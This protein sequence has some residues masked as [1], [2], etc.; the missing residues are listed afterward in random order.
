MVCLRILVAGSDVDCRS[1]DASTWALRHACVSHALDGRDALAKIF[2]EPAAFLACITQ[3]D[4]PFIDGYVLCKILRTDVLTRHIK[5]VM[6][7]ADARQPAVERA[8]RA[9]AN[10]VIIK[11]YAPERLR[12]E[13]ERL[14]NEPDRGDDLATGDGLAQ[15]APPVAKHVRL[16]HIHERFATAAPPLLPPPIVCPT[17]DGVLTYK[18]SQVGGVNEHN[19]EQWDYFECANGCGSFQ[20]RV[21]TR[22]LRAMQGRLT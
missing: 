6:V 17:C 20:Y 22:K 7:S 8:F 2:A 4:M 3:T 18:E 15:S 1:L 19:P 11:P 21:R 9:G 13:V 12:A 14:I 5:T 16:S 10:A